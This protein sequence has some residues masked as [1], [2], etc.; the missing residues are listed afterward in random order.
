M[1]ACGQIQ[2]RPVLADII[3]GLLTYFVDNPYGQVSFDANG[4]RQVGR[5]DIITT[6]LGSSLGLG[7]NAG[8]LYAPN[9]MLCDAFNNR[10]PLGRVTLYDDNH[11]TGGQVLNQFAAQL[12]AS[13]FP[14]YRRKIV[15][16]V[17][18]MNDFQ[19]GNYNSGQAFPG[20]KAALSALI[21]QIVQEGALPILFTSPHPNTVRYNYRQYFIENQTPMYWPAYHD[22]PVDP[23]TQNYPPASAS[24]VVRD[25]TGG[26]NPVEGDVRFWHGNEMM[27][28]IARAN[29]DSMILLDAEWA[30]FRYGVE[31]RGVD[32]LFDQPA[33]GPANLVHPNALG[34][35]LSFGR[36]INEFVSALQAQRLD[37]RIFRGD[38]A[39]A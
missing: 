35:Q 30:W 20:A 32:A 25:W 1:T 3:N 14:S 18:G 31:P 2:R 4:N 16:I 8:P 17:A 39:H 11:S 38:G 26:G 19:Q 24:K 21:S 27:R 15:T 37:Q 6:G 9:R 34:Y 36:V 33:M 10:W 13:T 28:S 22:A 12:A 7:D 23:E 29:R 5:Y